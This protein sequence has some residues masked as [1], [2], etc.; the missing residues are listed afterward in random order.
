MKHK[1]NVHDI[2]ND[3]YNC[4]NRT[5]FDS[6]MEKLTK[7]FLYEENP[8]SPTKKII[9]VK[10]PSEFLSSKSIP[11]NIPQPKHQPYK[12]LYGNNDLYKQPPSNKNYI[13][14]HANTKYYY[15]DD[16][17]V[18]NNNINNNVDM[19]WMDNANNVNMMYPNLMSSNN[20]RNVNENETNISRPIVT[21]PCNYENEFN[22]KFGMDN[23]RQQY[24]HQPQ[25]QYQQHQQQQPHY[26]NTFG[27]MNNYNSGRDD[28]CTNEF[29]PSYLSANRNMLLN[30]YNYSDKRFNTDF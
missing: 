27:G 19:P 1:F 12:P 4:D 8:L 23:Y 7:D 13:D 11:T 3:I 5:Q 20:K 2:C 17:G 29:S 22:Q 26:T 24:Q 10:T 28:N 6:I 14:I 30:N 21:E 18:N 15:Q 25:H 16:Y 9:H